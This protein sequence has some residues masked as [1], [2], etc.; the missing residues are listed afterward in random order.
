MNIQTIPKTV[1]SEGIPEHI[2]RKMLKAGQLPG[3]YSGTRFYVNV[4]QLRDVLNGA[5][6]PGDA[7]KAYFQAPTSKRG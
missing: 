6:R 4:D 2:L 7:R 3:F 5:M 1:K